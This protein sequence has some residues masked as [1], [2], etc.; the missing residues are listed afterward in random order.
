M[1]ILAYAR[2]SCLSAYLYSLCSRREPG[3]D[4][5]FRLGHSEVF[6]QHFNQ[7]LISSA[8]HGT[9]LEKNRKYAIVARLNQ[10]TLSGSWFDSYRYAHR[11]IFS[12][13]RLNV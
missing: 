1:K 3:F 6:G 4:Y 7:P 12:R 10:R 5:Y 11:S 8:I 13:L 2:I 9:L